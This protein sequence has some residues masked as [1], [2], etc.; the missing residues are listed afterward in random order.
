LRLPVLQTSK[1]NSVAEKMKNTRS[2]KGSSKKD[3]QSDEESSEDEDEEENADDGTSQKTEESDDK[4]HA[5]D[6]ESTDEGTGG[7]DSQTK[8]GK[9]LTKTKP[10]AKRANNNESS[11]DEDDDV[12]LNKL[13]T[14]LAKGD[15]QVASKKLASAR[16][17][18]SKV[19]WLRFIC[20][21][22]RVI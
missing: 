17:T 4:V 12:P 19:G 13:R 3:R 14:A 21:L 11:S 18:S 20:Y 7:I 10:V 9:K 2:S 6:D 16:K 22:Q 1:S 8:Q 5:R 15:K